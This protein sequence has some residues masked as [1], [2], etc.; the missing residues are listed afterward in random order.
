MNGFTPEDGSGGAVGLATYVQWVA[1]AALLAVVSS[2]ALQLV[3]D[4]HRT[5]A[6]IMSR[7][8]WL[9]T[10]G[11]VHLEA[12]ELHIRLY[13]IRC[14]PCATRAVVGEGEP[15]TCWRRPVVAFSFPSV[16]VRASVLDSDHALV[17]LVRTLVLSSTSGGWSSE[18]L[19][20]VMMMVRLDAR[21][22]A[23]RLDLSCRLSGVTELLA[24]V[25]LHPSVLAGLGTNLT[26]SPKA[27]ISLLASLDSFAL[28]YSS[29][30]V[31]IP[32][33]SAHRTSVKISQGAASVAVKFDNVRVADMAS[34]CNVGSFFKLSVE[35][36]SV[37]VSSKEL[38]TSEAADLVQVE[39]AKLSIECAMGATTRDTEDPYGL[40][41]PTEGSR[42]VVDIDSVRGWAELA[43]MDALRDVVEEWGTGD[44]E[45]ESVPH[46]VASRGHADVVGV[47]VKGSHCTGAETVLLTMDSLASRWTVEHLLPTA[48]ATLRFSF[49]SPVGYVARC[50]AFAAHSL[51]LGP[52][53]EGMFL[54]TVHSIR[55]SALGF[56]ME[57]VSARLGARHSAP[58][59][60]DWALSVSNA[61]ALW[62]VSTSEP[63]LLAIH[64][65]FAQ[66]RA[67]SSQGRM[68]VLGLSLFR[69]VALYRNDITGTMDPLATILCVGWHASVVPSLVQIDTLHLQLGLSGVSAAAQV[70]ESLG[71]K[72]ERIHKAWPARFVTAPV[73]QFSSEGPL[74]PAVHLDGFVQSRMRRGKSIG[75]SAWDGASALMHSQ[76]TRRLTSK[77]TVWFEPAVLPVLSGTRVEAAEAPCTAAVGSPA[78]TSFGWL[79]PLYSDGEDTGA[80]SALLTIQQRPIASVSAPR[81]DTLPPP[82]GSVASTDWCDI[83]HTGNTAFRLIV[84][85]LTAKLQQSIDDYP[86]RVRDSLPLPSGGEAWLP[87]PHSRRGTPSI[88]ARAKHN[89]VT[90][91][92]RTLHI[93]HTAVLELHLGG[94]RPFEHVKDVRK[95]QVANP[96]HS[97]STLGWFA[98][99]PEH[100]VAWRIAFN[101]T[102]VL[103]REC[104]NA[105]E[106]VLALLSRKRRASA[107][108]PRGGGR[109]RGIRSLDTDDFKAGWTRI[110]DQILLREAL[111]TTYVVANRMC[112]TEHWTSPS[113]GARTH[114]TGYV[115]VLACEPWVRPS[116]LLII[117]T[118]LVATEFARGIQAV[119]GVTALPPRIDL[120]EKISTPEEAAEALVTSA[121]QLLTNY[122][123]NGKIT[124]RLRS[125]DARVAFTTGE[126]FQADQLD[127]DFWDDVA[128]DASARRPSKA[129]NPTVGSALMTLRLGYAFSPDLPSD[130]TL[131]DVTLQLHSSCRPVNMAVPRVAF[132][133]R[134]VVS[135]LQRADDA[136][137]AV[138]V[139]GVLG[140]SHAGMLAGE[141]MLLHHGSPPMMGACAGVLEILRRALSPVC[142]TEE[143]ESDAQRISHLCK[144]SQ[145]LPAGLDREANA[146]ALSL[147]AV[148]QGFLH[149]DT[150][151]DVALAPIFE[152]AL[153]SV[154]AQ[155]PKELRMGAFV[156]GTAAS[157]ITAAAQVAIIAR[158]IPDPQP[159]QSFF[160]I[161]R[162]TRE[163][164]VR[165]AI[166]GMRLSVMDH[167]LASWLSV[168]APLWST[169]LEHR[170]LRS[171]ADESLFAGK[172]RH[173]AAAHSRR[174]RSRPQRESPSSAA[175]AAGTPPVSSRGWTWE[176][177]RSLLA[178]RQVSSEYI[179]RAREA[180]AKS[181]ASLD[182]DGSLVRLDLESMS[183]ATAFKIRD[184]AG[185]RDDLTS[186][187]SQ[188]GSFATL[189]RVLFDMHA[190]T[191]LHGLQVFLQ[192]FPDPLFDCQH[193]E[194]S[195]ENADLGI[196]FPRTRFFQQS[197]RHGLSRL[198]G[199]DAREHDGCSKVLLVDSCG[200]AKGAVLCTCFPLTVLR[201]R[202]DSV[203]IEIGRVRV[204]TS[205]MHIPAISDAALW[206]SNALKSPVVYPRRDDSA[207]PAAE[208]PFSSMVLANSEGI[209]VHVLTD[210]SATRH[211]GEGADIV[212]SSLC[213]R[214]D[215]TQACL[216]LSN[217][218][219]FAVSGP[220]ARYL[221]V[222][223]PG[224]HA[225]L[226]SVSMSAD[227][228]SSP[229][230]SGPLF[231]THERAGASS[232]RSI[233]HDAST[234]H[235]RSATQ[236]RSA[237]SHSEE[238]STKN[239]ALLFWGSIEGLDGPPDWAE[240]TSDTADDTARPARLS[241]QPMVTLCSDLIGWGYR[242]VHSFASHSN[243]SFQYA[244]SM[245]S[246]VELS[247]S[248]RVRMVR[249]EHAQLSDLEVRV[250]ETL[251]RSSCLRVTVR[252][253][254]T[255]VSFFSRKAMDLD[256]FATGCMPLPDPEKNLAPPSISDGGTGS[257][258]YACDV[259]TVA[260]G[261]EARFVHSSG[262]GPNG[263]LLAHI[264]QA[265]FLS[266]ASNTFEQSCQMSGVARD[267]FTAP[268]SGLYNLVASR[269]RCLLHLEDTKAL[270]NF[271]DVLAQKIVAL[272]PTMSSIP[273]HILDADA[274]AEAHPKGSLRLPEQ[275][276][277]AAETRWNSL[278]SIL[279]SDVQAEVMDSRSTTAALVV[280]ESFRS[281]AGV[282]SGADMEHY[283]FAGE[284]LSAYFVT[285][286]ALFQWRAE[287]ASDG[288]WDQTPS[289]VTSPVDSERVHPTPQH[290]HAAMV[291]VRGVQARAE[292]ARVSQRPM[293]ATAP[294]PDPEP[295]PREVMSGSPPPPLSRR[296][297]SS[298]VMHSAQ[299]HRLTF[300]RVLV[301]TS[302][303]VSMT[304]AHL[305]RRP[306][307]ASMILPVMPPPPSPYD[308]QTMRVDIRVTELLVTADPAAISAAMFIAKEVSDMSDFISLREAE[309][310]PPP[311][312][313]N[314]VRTALDA[315]RE[316]R[317]R[318]S[319][320][321]AISA[322]FVR[323]VET[324]P[325][326][327]PLQH[328]V[329]KTIRPSLRIGQMQPGES[330]EL[331]P[332]GSLGSEGVSSFLEHE[333]ALSSIGQQS[334]VPPFVS[335]L[336]SPLNPVK[337]RDGTSRRKLGRISNEEAFRE[338]WSLRLESQ[339][340]A[341][342]NRLS[343]AGVLD[344]QLRKA[345]VAP[346]ATLTVALKHLVAWIRDDRGVELCT[347]GVQSVASRIQA[348]EDQRLA[349]SL[350]ASGI[351]L[352]DQ[353]I[354]APFHRM[355]LLLP[356]GAMTGHDEVRPSVSGSLLA[357]TAGRGTGENLLE[358]VAP[359]KEQLARARRFLGMPVVGPKGPGLSQAS[360][361]LPELIVLSPDRFPD[362]KPWL[363]SASFEEDEED[364]EES[365]RSKGAPPTGVRALSPFAQSEDESDS[366]SYSQ[367][368]AEAIASVVELPVRLSA[369]TIEVTELPYTNLINWV[370]IRSIQRL[371]LLRGWNP[372]SPQVPDKAATTR[373]IVRQLEGMHNAL[374]RSWLSQEPHLSPRVSR[375]ATFGESPA[376]SL[377]AEAT[378]LVPWRMA[379]AP[380]GAVRLHSDRAAVARG[381]ASTVDFLRFSPDTGSDLPGSEQ[382]DPV[383]PSHSSRPS[384][385]AMPQMSMLEGERA[386]L[387]FVLNTDPPAPD[388]T[389]V[390]RHAEIDMLPIRL[391]LALGLVERL[392]SLFSGV[393]DPSQ[394]GDEV[395]VAQSALGDPSADDAAVKAASLF[396]ALPHDRGL[397][398][399]ASPSPLAESPI[400]VEEVP[401][402]QEDDISTDEEDVSPRAFSRRNVFSGSFPVSLPFRKRMRRQQSRP[403]ETSPQVV[404]SRS[405]LFLSESV[406]R[407]VAPPRGRPSDNP[408]HDEDTGGSDESIQLA[409]ALWI[410]KGGRWFV[411]T[412]AASSIHG[413]TWSGRHQLLDDGRTLW[414]C[415]SLEWV[416]M[417]TSPQLRED[418]MV[419]RSWASWRHDQLAAL[420]PPGSSE[421]AVVL[422]SR[423][424][425]GISQARS[426]VP[427]AGGAQLP[428]FTA[429]PTGMLQ[430]AWPSLRE[431]LQSAP[432]EA[433]P[434][435]D[436][437]RD[438]LVASLGSKPSV[439]IHSLRFNETLV[440]VSIAPEG[441]VSMPRLSHVV[442]KIHTRQYSDL[443]RILLEDL[444]Q[445]LRRDLIRDILSQGSRNLGN[446]GS[447]FA[448]LV[449]QRAARLAREDDE[450]MARE[451]AEDRRGW[452][453]T[454]LTPARRTSPRP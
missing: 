379:L 235:G 359:S 319:Y 150:D 9:L 376:L 99:V 292:L 232:S 243:T 29:A 434:H 212:L 426:S 179:Q 100:W 63:P 90:A 161:L 16:R 445:R 307:D 50:T 286:L 156:S 169:L 135:V 222:S 46:S 287:V 185:V 6:W 251:A 337:Q 406:L 386:L 423:F 260:E 136:S 447:F 39:S 256:V 432:V 340:T 225:R 350:T 272:L 404:A 244:S 171:W 425:F 92:T 395:S 361:L 37:D 32:G 324:E 125:R 168:M 208:S 134:A 129:A 299:G 220:S 2:S 388:G 385:W 12:P 330:I 338:L 189:Q 249:I 93:A 238:E 431:S 322:A 182:S 118:A 321:Q 419:Q 79:P 394:P 214:L 420:P 108:S 239:I 275:V 358:A 127:P 7:A 290:P 396:R 297:Q 305:D 197:I 31:S 65:S 10:S 181:R 215:P 77:R 203:S 413:R 174:F 412:T 147:W 78:V 344:Q 242:M 102:R 364:E 141:K 233:D 164:R 261:I 383:L 8:I 85:C 177:P 363:R 397:A 357:P 45:P 390:I 53:A 38:E 69:F 74:C 158:S 109:G 229:P 146:R 42:V 117:E 157:I 128:P 327:A 365:N 393:S 167:P 28:D 318:V 301:P 362:A 123:S 273:A 382:S 291:G 120:P 253:A 271:V 281:V 282:T 191:E 15:A 25:Q 309:Q 389:L 452:M 5:C 155:L 378:N 276:V 35:S 210:G 209:A 444:L 440:N 310:P 268:Q 312:G 33:P 451:A 293:A 372:S 41:F 334:S 454:M 296:A 71:R 178:E 316:L 95:H 131:S 60:V 98:L 231:R 194:L 226:R 369:A 314:P 265:T 236:F 216:T 54:E 285:G 315:Y 4:F 52:L 206:G 219:L 230:A 258:W 302:V 187:L 84:R 180:L 371:G 192:R 152:V 148:T 112:I 450:A 241:H 81:E 18:I 415:D 176:A 88:L 36:L 373:V 87:E 367:E 429:L 199:M 438:G 132:R 114:P 381:R 139:T 354:A 284:S 94:P 163:F 110:A 70:I 213:L 20:L 111:D 207:F 1:F 250:W 105:A 56:L 175:A 138:H 195:V 245:L 234:A 66:F 166:A 186:Q 439:W 103:R 162:Y 308:I 57:I 193:I 80:E 368:P 306:K 204:T 49:G 387:R 113:F 399:L 55:A 43:S 23:I 107:L 332:T 264:S 278:L 3:L 329:D 188:S 149:S 76:S 348:F 143:F 341:E 384:I 313:A 403:A 190:E 405:N 228:G 346:A 325:V 410:P 333:V 86:S 449:T 279:V 119:L 355:I 82:C 392:V 336:P 183:F 283:R 366:E 200:V 130:W 89:G 97:R 298:M 353:R 27:T 159:F 73:P 58:P 259:E 433:M 326:P 335:W 424:F 140:N 247:S 217:V 255:R 67:R 68:Q 22:I 145:L 211:E 17:G 427:G 201:P 352:R 205:A 360:A 75:M 323:H 409:E 218:Q 59:V 356:P 101:E 224:V 289:A 311:D 40:T 104:D 288:A 13:W 408:K 47:T 391:R 198:V 453:D 377:E 124:H 303:I 448:D 34:L 106:A 170:E 342:L 398:G 133:E 30:G 51:W 280:L 122:S 83:P 196:G 430:W 248:L 400:L 370:P 443:G 345:R 347:A 416:S 115:D 294:S 44:T 417:G 263:R 262:T 269:V 300:R 414:L 126:V 144:L 184:I 274:P 246:Q 19:R 266:A 237:S 96:G 11:R 116:P 328:P 240:V 331:R 407:R 24:Q 422:P 270:L 257:V 374:L 91:P 227:D 349:V 304:T 221:L 277:S 418:P 72:L 267:P 339:Q 142:D 446:I 401:S 351:D 295:A 428:Q 421:F 62:E 436:T 64:N 165:A 320:L 172:R 317:W 441:V 442:F 26:G 223:F 154:S 151:R 21:D 343:L 121:R 437:R 402:P 160:T 14:A 173:D 411:L 48:N 61:S 137:S 153:A 375:P 252:R 435:L 254:H 380:L 202:V